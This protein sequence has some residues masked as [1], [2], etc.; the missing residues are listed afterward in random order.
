MKKF[1]FIVACILLASFN[2]N[3]TSTVDP[4]VPANG[5]PLA[6]LPIRNNFNATHNDINGLQAKFPVTLVNGGTSATTAQGALNNLN[7][8]PLG[9]LG[10]AAYQVSPCQGFSDEQKF[11]AAQIAAK[12]LNLGAMTYPSGCVYDAQWKF[13]AVGQNVN[14]FGFGGSGNEKNTAQGG[15]VGPGSLAFSYYIPAILANAPGETVID[16]NNQAQVT[17]NGIQAFPQTSAGADPYAMSA[18]MYSSVNNNTGCCNQGTVNLINSSVG[19]GNT[20]F[21]YPVDYDLNP[22]QNNGVKTGTITTAGTGY[23]DGTYTHVPFTSGAGTN[24]YAA[25]VVV[26][27]GAV[28]AVNL[29]LQ[30]I[31]AAPGGSYAVNDVLSISNANLGGFGSGFQYTVNSL[32]SKITGSGAFPNMLPHFMNSF[33][34]DETGCALCSNFSD[35]QVIGN[36]FT[37]G[38]AIQAIFGGGAN[39][40]TNNKFEDDTNA[41]DLGGPNGSDNGSSIISENVF[42]TNSFGGGFDLRIGQGNGYNANGNEIDSNFNTPVNPTTAAATA[43]FVLG[44]VASLSMVNVNNNLWK[45]QPAGGKLYCVDLVA[46][47]AMD[48]INMQGN[49]CNGSTIVDNVHWGQIP[50]HFVADFVGPHGFHSEMGR[51]VGIGTNIPRAQFDTAGLTGVYMA[52]FITPDGSGTPLVVQSKTGTSPLSV[53]QTAYW[54]F[55]DGSG[56]TVTESVAAANGT[57]H[58]SGA[59]WVS[60]GKINAGGILNGTDNYVTT[61]FGGTT[62][63]AARSCAAWVK[64]TQTTYAN[65]LAPIVYY[66]GTAGQYLTLAVNDKYGSGTNHNGLTLEVNAAAITY[67]APALYNGSYHLVGFSMAASSTLATAKLWM[68]AVQLSTVAFS[69]SPTTAIN[70]GTGNMEIGGHNASSYFTNASIDEV[71]C[72]NRELSASEWTQLYNSNTGTQYPYSSGPQTVALSKWTD[73]A[74]NVL[75]AFGPTATLSL[76]TSTF[77]NELDVSGGV[78]IGTGY[79]GIGTASVNGM[80]VQGN[81]GIGTTSATG[82]FHLG[83]AAAHAGQSTC[84]TTNGQIGYCTTT[85]GAGG[86]CTCTGL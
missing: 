16:T 18:F 7:A 79:A 58:G 25:S 6:S 71:G 38:Q 2:A 55:D 84:W 12:N 42:T 21:G 83:N 26:S 22:L 61:T 80:I 43:S 66:G 44:G 53:G 5:A 19:G 40:I 37:A 27:G 63:T 28:T 57:W 76:G 30:G 49:I 47:F 54:K 24:A 29:Y 45:S 72:W 17:L 15:F 23:V 74:G 39:Q 35:S 77:T 3:A 13:S 59:E 81:V 70:T 9:S 85:V 60:P 4:T 48:Y 36:T 14:I 33:L 75:S 68:D 32:Y 11:S 78:A 64:T 31:R 51:N 62:G 50:A 52:P 8:T 10:S 56:A 82:Q 69:A 41:V 73:V 86:A 34:S 46:G 20:I 1:L 67:S 65:N